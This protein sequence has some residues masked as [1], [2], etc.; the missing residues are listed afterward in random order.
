MKVAAT[1]V[2]L[3]G[4]ANAFAPAQNVNKG[5]ALS[6]VED[7]AGST[8]PFKAFDPLGLAT[9][10]SDST[11]AWFRAA[12]LKHSRA[13]MLA[14]SGYLVQAAGFHFPGML[15]SDVSFETLS[16]MKPLDAWD[17]VPDLGKAQIYFTIFF[18]EVVSEAKGTHYTK[19]GDYPTIVFPN[20]N[21]ASSDPEKLKVQQSRELNNGRL[22]MIAIMSFVS[23]ANIEGSVPALI[24]NPMF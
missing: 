22:A 5:T 11:L 20:I 17:A 1:L 7:M 15:S 4:V 13:A 14:T 16:A 9:L 6:A 23:A 10:G 21:F 3:A 12:E 18:A 19:G 2:A 8:M 24:G